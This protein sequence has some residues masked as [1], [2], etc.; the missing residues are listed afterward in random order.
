M[1]GVNECEAA[2]DCPL[3]RAAV[4]PLTRLREALA[5]HGQITLRSEDLGDLMGVT[6]FP[7]NTI[8][9]HRDLGMPEWRSTLAH[10]SHHL[11]RGPVPHSHAEHEE[12]LVR[13]LTAADLV[14]VEELTALP[15]TLDDDVMQVL[16]ARLGVD[17][18]QADDGISPPT[19]PFPVVA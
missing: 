8:A 12:V 6:H 18:E 2:P 14:P 5:Q 10:E 3:H 9:L 17:H 16:A 7:S 19:I 11:I 15:R 4:C 13:H 1:I